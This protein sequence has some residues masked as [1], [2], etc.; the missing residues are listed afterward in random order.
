GTSNSSHMQNNAVEHLLLYQVQPR[1]RS[2]IPNYVPLVG[3]DDV[4]ELVQDGTVLAIR[5]L[6]SAKR[7]GRRVTAGNLAFYTAK[8]LRAGR[9]S[10]GQGK[11][12]P[13]NPKARLDGT[14][15]IQSL[16]EPIAEDDFSGE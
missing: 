13:L 14:C 3:A 10:T 11:N 12:D 4:E 8:M 15:R 1:L 9:R 16:D 7:S 5:L 2:I 6:N